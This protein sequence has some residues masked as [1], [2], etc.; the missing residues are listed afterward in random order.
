MSEKK[1][2][3]GGYF[4]ELKRRKVVRVAIAY[5][6]GAWFL[7]QIAAAAVAPGTRPRASRVSEKS[8]STRREA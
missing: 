1:P 2:G 7:M 5:I 6:V 4:E 8:A 3:L